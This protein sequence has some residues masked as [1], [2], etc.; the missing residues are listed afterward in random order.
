M[1]AFFLLN[2]PAGSDQWKVA[3][4]SGS[5]LVSNLKDAHAAATPGWK[6]K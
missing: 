3:E 4:R 1:D 5:Q 6:I 2:W